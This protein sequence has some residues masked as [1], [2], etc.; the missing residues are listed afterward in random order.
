MSSHA[1]STNL[2]LHLYSSAKRLGLMEYAPVKRLFRIAYFLYKD[3]LEDPFKDLTRTYPALFQNGNIVDVGANVGH[4][5]LIFARALSPQTKVFAF[6]PDPTNFIALKEAIAGA[7]AHQKIQPNQAA[8]GEHDGT[9]DLWINQDHHAD[10]R[11][12]TEHF[13]VSEEFQKSPS[14][15]QKTVSVPLYSLDSF[16]LRENSIEHVRF[17]KIDVQGYELQVCR[18]MT[19]TLDSSP[20][21][22]VAF[23][24]SPESMLALGYSAEELL[25]FFIDRKFHL[26]RL[27]RKALLVPFDDPSTSR[28]L[29]ERG[30]IDVIASRQPLT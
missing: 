26:Y 21:A 29:Q 1:V 30:Y 20:H 23:E 14:G 7:G 15:A 8:V 12:A 17:I 28:R 18:G 4:T 22:S 9:I 19:R 16:L 6:E 24:Y 10:H 5:S 3:L 11:I 27:E 25:Q 2:A 13:V